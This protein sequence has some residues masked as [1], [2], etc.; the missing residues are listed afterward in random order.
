MNLF[1]RNIVLV[2]R[3]FFRLA[4]LRRLFHLF[5]LVPGRCFC[6]HFPLLAERTRYLKEN[7][8]GVSE[9]CKVMED[10]RN[11]ERKENMIEVA[12]KLLFD[13][14]LTLEKIAACVD[15]S[16]D[17]LKRLQAGQSV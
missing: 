1:V 10:M 11:E 17:E 7:P 5:P 4:L 16:L 9:M 2:F 12:K 13:G 15:L 3:G 14:T 6:L 8:K